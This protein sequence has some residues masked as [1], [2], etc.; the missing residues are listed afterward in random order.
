[1][2]TQPINYSGTE[3]EIRKSQSKCIGIVVINKIN[4]CLKLDR[5]K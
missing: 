1:M 3:K 4:T 2:E 5:D